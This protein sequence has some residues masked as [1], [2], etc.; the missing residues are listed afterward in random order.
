MNDRNK[1]RKYAL[2]CERSKQTK[3]NLNTIDIE[4]KI[5]ERTSGKYLQ[6][7]LVTGLLDNESYGGW[8][9]VDVV[10]MLS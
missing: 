3:Y 4:R 7:Y 6:S 8:N 9:K 1:L 5:A 10:C 2:L